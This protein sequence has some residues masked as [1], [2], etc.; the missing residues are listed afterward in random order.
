MN[1]I[2]REIMMIFTKRTKIL[3]WICLLSALLLTAEPGPAK[4]GSPSPDLNAIGVLDLN[5]AITIALAGNPTLAAARDRV[6]QAQAR[7]NQ[8]RSTYWPRVD[9]T[10]S[11]SRV[12]LADR[13]LDQQQAQ[14][15]FFNPTAS[16]EDPETYYRAGLSATWLLFNGFERKW[17]NASAHVG[18]DQSNMGRKETRRRLLASVARTYHAAQLA[19]EN[20]T[21][22][23]ADA[24]FN[25]RLLDDAK[26]RH[27]VGTGSLSDTL[28]FEIRVN[29][30]RTSEI[31]AAETYAS[32]RYALAAI[33]GIADARLPAHVKL[34]PMAAE[35]DT[36]M[37][38][39]AVQPLIDYAFLHRPDILQG[40][41]NR[42]QADL[43]VKIA[44]A[45]YY[46]AMNVSVAINGE[47][48]G[49]ASFK[50]EDFGNTLALGLSYNLFSGGLTGAKVDEA[51]A[52]LAEATREWNDT[53]LQ[54]GAQIR[55]AHAKLLAAQRQLAL[56]RDNARLVEKQRELVE[57]EYNAGRGS[58]VRLNEA[59]RDLITARGRLALALV[60]LRQ[61][62][63]E[64]KTETGRILEA[65]PAE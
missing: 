11:G 2:E 12:S 51:K 49:D 14:A 19:F 8:A 60:S 36:D 54:A 3:L 26:I 22:A 56:Q 53:R 37:H 39:P 1:T 52:R 15:R 44:R 25:Q 6:R 30:A 23:R 55:S 59:Q 7:L 35:N 17:S 32:T 29:A 43:A 58:L 65:Y 47:H 18:I 5:T 16:I 46:P 41:L 57:K 4:A 24:A 50:N 9:A 61:A 40:N 28:N 33:L 13:T 34:A 10:A 31:K 38:P 21:I 45:G 20:L 27:R 48:A 64:L 62:W 42:Q 63:F